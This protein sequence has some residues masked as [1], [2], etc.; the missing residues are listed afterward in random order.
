M[1]SGFAASEWDWTTLLRMICEGRARSCVTPAALSLSRI[2]FLLAHARCYANNQA[3]PSVKLHRALA[4]EDSVN[5]SLP[6]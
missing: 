1:W 3:G 6:C 5:M 2:Q 4:S